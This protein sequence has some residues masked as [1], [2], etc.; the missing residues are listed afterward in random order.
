MATC[1]VIHIETNQREGGGCKDRDI[2]EK[3]TN[4]GRL[5]KEYIPC[6]VLNSIIT[7]SVRFFVYRAER[8]ICTY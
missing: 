1:I 5:W 7:P 3:K 4:I 8:K 6:N 2:S